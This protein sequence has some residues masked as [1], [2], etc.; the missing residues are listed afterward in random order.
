[1]P[2]RGTLAA[3]LNL[4]NLVAQLG[5]FLVVFLLNGI[6]ELLAQLIKAGYACLW[7]LPLG[8]CR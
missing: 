3:G 6:A 1:M 7:L 8:A 4:T 5:G 2:L